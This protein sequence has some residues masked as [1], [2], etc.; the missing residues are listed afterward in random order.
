MRAGFDKDRVSDRVSISFT[1]NERTVTVAVDPVTPLV[2]VLRGE[3]GLTGTKQGC[4]HNGECGACTVL[5]DGQPVRSCLTPMGKVGGHN[6]P[7]DRGNWAILNTCT[8]SRRRSLPPAPS[9][10]AIALPP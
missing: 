10:A 1:V 2:D 5:I 4:D 3:L 8:R 7:H 6:R 9:S